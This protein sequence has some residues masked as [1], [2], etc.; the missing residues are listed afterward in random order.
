MKVRET[1]YFWL[2]GL[3]GQALGARYRQILRENQQGIPP[4]ATKHLLVKMLEHCK[5]SIPY[6]GQM[7]RDR[8]DSFHEDPEEYLRRFPVLTRRILRDRFDELKSN[9]LRERKYYLNTTGDSTG[10]PVCFI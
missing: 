2:V 3:R 7:I 6:Y 5:Q 9:D 1:A 10:E 8:G 4:D